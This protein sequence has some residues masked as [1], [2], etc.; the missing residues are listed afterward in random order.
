MTKS[1]DSLFMSGHYNRQETDRERSLLSG[2]QEANFLCLFLSLCVCHNGATFRH[3][4]Q[5]AVII[6]ASKIGKDLKT[7][8]CLP[9]R[10][11][12]QLWNKENELFLFSKL[13]SSLNGISRPTSLIGFVCEG[14]FFFSFGFNSNEKTTRAAFFLYL[15]ILSQLASLK[16]IAVR[17]GK[18]KSR[19]PSSKQQS[20]KCALFN[21]DYRS[22]F[23]S[24][25]QSFVERIGN[26]ITFPSQRNV[27][28]ERERNGNVVAHFRSKYHTSERE[29]EREFFSF[30]FFLKFEWEK[31]Q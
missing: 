24:Q 19:V 15:S 8:R 20:P 14:D 7:S 29:R 6:L 26:G 4:S 1:I 11:R 21:F 2:Q 31:I 12:V 28:R 17:S 3:P 22:R 25:T 27:F 9:K 18:S 10:K 13:F 5:A 16:R 30:S 23:Q